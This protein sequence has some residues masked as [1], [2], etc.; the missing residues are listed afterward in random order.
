MKEDIRL[1][2]SSDELDKE[3]GKKIKTTKLWL[4]ITRKENCFCMWEKDHSV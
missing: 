4:K 2:R 1:I 3:K